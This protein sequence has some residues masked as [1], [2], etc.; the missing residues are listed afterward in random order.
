[1]D[2]AGVAVIDVS[3]PLNPQVIRYVSID[4]ATSDF[5]K[6]VAA[7]NLAYA[8]TGSTLY[9]F[10]IVAGQLL[11]QRSIN[12][13]AEQA[14]PQ[15]LAV[16]GG[17]VYLLTSYIRSYPGDV[18]GQ[19]HLHKILAGQVIG[20][21]AATLNL[22]GSNYVADVPTHIAAVPGFV[23][24]SGLNA[25]TNADSAGLAIIADGANGLQMTAP[26][27][28]ALG[29]LCLAANGSGTVLVAGTNLSVLDVRAPQTGAVVVTNY[30][31]PAPPKALTVGYGRAYVAD[32]NNGLQ[33][34]A[35]YQ[36]DTNGQPPSISLGANFPLNPALAPPGSSVVF[37]AAT[38]D[39]VLRE[40]L[41]SRERQ[42]LGPDLISPWDPGFPFR[43]IKS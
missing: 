19:H 4:G 27:T 30:A 25:T 31:L 26:P 12:T 17:Y 3:D 8:V 9:L 34:V 10:D 13:T 2:R 43:P 20:A 40:L 42:D 15:D 32:N 16:S 18:P 37:S 7:G 6:V 24:L 23:Y 41:T 36:P 39:D 35:Y 1:M 33:V 28:T 22:A 38:A 21:D 29:A 14:Q 5:V 11:D